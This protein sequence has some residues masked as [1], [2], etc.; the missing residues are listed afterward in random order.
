[1]IHV[2]TLRIAMLLASVLAALLAAV[3]AI[4][5]Y[6][7]KPVR[8][9]VPSPP[10]GGNDIMARLASQKLTE[11]WGRQV[12]VDN[13]PGGGGAIAFEMAARADPNG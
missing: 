12:I 10:G 8:V 1:M 13:R 11:A 4:G 9:I 5:A 7:E 3:P 6:P 2:R